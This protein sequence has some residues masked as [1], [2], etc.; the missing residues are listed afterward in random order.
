MKKHFLTS[1]LNVLDKKT[2]S[3]T[4]NLS[5]IVKKKKKMD[6]EVEQQR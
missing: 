6:V 1:S 2:E 3:A 5:D 4:P